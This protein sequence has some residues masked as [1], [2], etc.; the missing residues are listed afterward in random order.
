MVE[1]NLYTIVTILIGSNHTD[2][3][4]CCIGK[5]SSVRIWECDIDE[6]GAI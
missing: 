2:Q 4:D 1:Q 5:F 6:L 3:F